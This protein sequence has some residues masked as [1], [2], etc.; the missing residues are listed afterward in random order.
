MKY[1][2]IIL[3]LIIFSSCSTRQINGK[4]QTFTEYVILNKY[5][6]YKGKSKEDW[7]K[8]PSDNF[9][10]LRLIKWFKSNEV[11]NMQRFITIKEYD[12]LN[13][14]LKEKY[15]VVYLDP[16]TKCIPY[17]YRVKS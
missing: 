6:N 17:G 2:I 1:L 9:P 10:G 13:D 4:P 8:Q 5:S 12:N 3:C 15:E 16:E 7:D 14:N 11:E